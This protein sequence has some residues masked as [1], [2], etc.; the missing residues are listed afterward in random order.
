M[1]SQDG[2]HHDQYLVQPAPIGFRVDPF[3][4]PHPKEKGGCGGD[5]WNEFLE[6]CVDCIL[7]FSAASHFFWGL[8]AVVQATVSTIDFDFMEY[9]R[10][11]L[12]KGYS[13]ALT[14]FPPH[15]RPK[16]RNLLCKL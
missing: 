13:H 2:N 5:E 9:A 15:L 12:I 4:D 1:G 16:R 3:F 6:G 10:N 14:T 8:W 11:R 7:V